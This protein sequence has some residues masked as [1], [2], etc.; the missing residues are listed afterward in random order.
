MRWQIQK[1]KM[2]EQYAFKLIKDETWLF[3]NLVIE[4]GC[5]IKNKDSLDKRDLSW[6]QE[7]I[8][9]FKSMKELTI[10]PIN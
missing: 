7:E 3:F 9:I 8:D 5:Y 2:N 4:F 6:Y 10:M 1:K